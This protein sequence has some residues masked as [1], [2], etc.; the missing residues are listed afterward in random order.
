MTNLKKT[1]GIIIY[2]IKN[3]Q[4]Q[5]LLLHHRGAY[6]NFPKGRVDKGEEGDEFKTAFREVWEETGIAKDALKLDKNFR[7]T[8]QYKFKSEWQED[9]GQPVIK[10]AILY[11]GELI[12]PSAIKIS[13]EHLNFGWFNYNEAFKKLYYKTGHEVI[14]KADLYLRQGILP[15]S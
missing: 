4:P 9:F 2:Q 14:K 15:K 11:I 7:A 8:Y 12:K 10:E 6:W 5:Y 3:G 1:I 13:D